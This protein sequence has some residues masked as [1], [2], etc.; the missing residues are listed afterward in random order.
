VI[1]VMLY[2]VTQ[3]EVKRYENN[4]NNLNLITTTL[5]R[6]VY[7]RVSHL[8]IA[9]DIWIKL[10]NTYEDPLRLSFFIMILTIVNIKS[11]LKNLESL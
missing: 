5:S 1:L 10:C 6:N 7:D 3:S 8:E 9:H 4:Y 11:L 2:D